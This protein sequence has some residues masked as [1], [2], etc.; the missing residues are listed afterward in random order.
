MASSPTVPFPSRSVAMTIEKGRPWGHV[1]ARPDDLEIVRSDAA[2]AAA[3]DAGRTVAPAAGD[4]HRT[5]GNRDPAAA[6]ELNE[7]PIDLLDVTID[8]TA[9]TAAAH[10]VVRRPWFR[11]GWWFG[12]VLLILNAQHLHGWHVVSR[13][14]PNDGRAESCSWGPEL[15]LRQR[16]AAR[17]RLPTGTH[18]P[19]PLIE[20]RSFR[21]GEWS[22]ERPHRVFVDGLA[23][24]S[25]RTLHVAVRADAG[26]IYG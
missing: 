21:R 10:V 25:V 22:F 14:H 15:S 11:G 12:R 4:V 18:V 16:M 24:G 13:G 2:L 19:H 17:R 8:G 20:T 26:R 9:T 3:I 6:T 1:V 5:I 23:A 7:L